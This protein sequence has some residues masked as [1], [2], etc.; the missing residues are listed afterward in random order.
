MPNSFTNTT[1]STTYKDDF[2]D[3]DHYH[4]ILFNSG[5]ALQARELTQLQ[6]ITQNELERL[7]RHIFKEGSVVLPGGLTLDRNYEF[8][9]LETSDTSAF[10][11]NDVIQGL[12]SSVQAKILQIVAATDTDP[13][14]FYVKYINSSTS[15]GIVNDPV[16][17]TP[18]EFVQRTASSDSIRVQVVS[19]A[20]NF[21]VGRGTR[22]SVNN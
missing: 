12:T 8:V 2:K 20:G 9:K 15:T 4:R 11:V 17:F 14:T 19:I 13:A 22:A 7:G 10:S 16:R 5:R 18:G 1:F 21:A 3:S 6:T